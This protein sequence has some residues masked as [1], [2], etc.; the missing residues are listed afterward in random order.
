MERERL[1]DVA[2]LKRE[3]YT[4]AADRVCKG[5][6]VLRTVSSSRVGGLDNARVPSGNCEEVKVSA[7]KL[8]FVQPQCTLVCSI[9]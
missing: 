1:E 3:G 6:L 5:C 4:R 2:A 8:V 7:I 9:L